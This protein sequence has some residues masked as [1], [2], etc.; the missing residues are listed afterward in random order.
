MPAAG[1]I[2]LGNIMSENTWNMMKIFNLIRDYRGMSG[3]EKQTYY[4][5]KCDYYQYFVQM[6][7]VL[8]CIVSLTFLVSDYKLNQSDIW[9]TLIPRLSILPALA[10]YLL[11]LR[12][13]RSS[14][15]KVFMDYLLSHLIVIATIWAIFHLQDRVHAS[16]GF[17]MM[18]LIFLTIGYCSSPG[19][20]ILSYIIFFLE[21]LISNQFNH[22][23]NLDVIMSLQIPC[24]I[25]VVLGQV[26][27]NMVYL[28]HYKM[29]CQLQK[30]L[31]LDPLTQ[32]FNR[33]K[34]EEMIQDNK[35]IHADEPLSLAMID[36]DFFKVVNDTYGHYV[37]DETLIYLGR[38]L[39]EKAGEHD[40]VIRFG[41][42]EF[43]VLM[44]HCTPEEAFQRIDSFRGEIEKD[45]NSPVPFQI[46]AGIAEY[47]GNFHKAVLKVDYALYQAK[48]RGRNQVIR[49]G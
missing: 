8:T 7:L 42:E 19:D 17:T 28:D 22:Y 35:I 11:I 37:G 44:N 5:T 18:N 12:K 31:N 36:I 15:L 45:T 9:P 47:K 41:G 16:E 34:L 14:R 40:M 46:S 38:K 25:A 4:Q 49:E 20:C 23:S 6:A 10:V 2:L 24:A 21:I 32:V 48:K 3:R 33:H 1:T 26:S 43:I 13:D 39:K 29:E 30:S 27:L